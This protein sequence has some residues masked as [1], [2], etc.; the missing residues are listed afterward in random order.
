MIDGRYKHGMGG[1]TGRPPEFG[2]WLGMRRRCSD[3][4]MK[5]YPDY[6]GRGIKVCPEW[7]DNFA[8][9]FE[10]MGPRPSPLHEIDR[11]DN[12]GDYSPQNCR[13]VTRAM[14]AN[15]RRP[16]RIAENCK[17]GHPLDAVNTYHRPDGKRGCKVCRSINM[18]SFYE[19][20]KANG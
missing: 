14:Q 20:N 9:F 16:R 8:A 2:V 3:V 19:R 11:I 13:W 15:N 12:D 5:S 7:A 1:R 4:K 6:G 18:R 17:S 10:S